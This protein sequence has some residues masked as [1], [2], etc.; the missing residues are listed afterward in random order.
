MNLLRD[1]FPGWDIQVAH[2][3]ELEPWVGYL[4]APRSGLWARGE[5][6][7]PWQLQFI[8]AQHDGDDWLYRHDESIRLALTDA[9]LHD[10]R[11]IPFAR[12]EIVLLSKARLVREL[13]EQ[14]FAAALPL[15]GETSRRRLREW[16]PEQHPWRGRL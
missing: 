10:E 1:R 16:L 9:I 6:A 11:G 12:P 14:D 3:G 8:L 5:P 7:G 2:D 13:D 4:D 15:L